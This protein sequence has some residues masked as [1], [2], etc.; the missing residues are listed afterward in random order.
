MIKTNKKKLQQEDWKM[1]VD[2]IGFALAAF[3]TCERLYW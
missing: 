3:I 1:M 2:I